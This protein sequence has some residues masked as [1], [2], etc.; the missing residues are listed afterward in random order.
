MICNALKVKDELSM[1]CLR[2]SQGLFVLLH[3]IC[4][5]PHMPNKGW[6]PCCK[7]HY[8]LFSN[9]RNEVPSR[10]LPPKSNGIGLGIQP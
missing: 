6:P 4:F 7:Y 8:Q 5:P 1:R 9:M 3:L 2:P 10:D